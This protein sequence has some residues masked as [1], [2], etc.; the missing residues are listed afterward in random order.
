V[1]RAEEAAH[2]DSTDGYGA[3]PPK[4]PA[5]IAFAGQNSMSIRWL[6]RPM[7][8]R[9]TD[10]ELIEEVKSL[11]EGLHSKFVDHLEPVH[12]T[13]RTRLLQIFEVWRQ[14]NLRRIVDLADAAIPM[15]EQ[16]RLVPGC[17]LTRGVFETVGIQ[18]YIHKKMVE[19]TE[20]SDPES[21]HKLFLSALFGR[22][23]DASWPET[24]I[25]VMTAI[26][27]M[28]KEFKMIRGEYNHLC[29]Y[30]HSNLKGG[31]GAYVRQEGDELEAH[32]GTNPL[33]LDMATWGLVPLHVILV[34]AAEI[35]N[36]LSN[37]YPNFVALAEKYSPDRPL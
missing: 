37:F 34:I 16:C 8:E 1:I 6:G 21:L 23:D 33:G 26:D 5:D 15:F 4:N 18:Y 31:F 2:G 32:F 30:A 19:Y 14:V 7:S 17:T 24:A 28:D 13:P 9:L 12:S 22:R 20:K 29:E 11:L 36:R 27:H 35:N 3:K 10:Q 25:Q